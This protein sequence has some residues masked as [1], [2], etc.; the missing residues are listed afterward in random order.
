IAAVAFAL[1]NMDFEIGKE[2]DLPIFTGQ[3]LFTL[4]ATTEEKTKIA[5]PLGE[6]EVYKVRIFTDFS[7]KL[8]AK[9]D[10]LAY[11]TTD[12]HHVLARIDADF[13]VGTISAELT[14]YQPGKQIALSE[15]TGAANG[16]GGSGKP[17]AP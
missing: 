17:P 3:K 12:E 5:T 4:K 13:L 6:R 7:G 9:R 15:L 14:D 8:A 2:R 10:M 1:R 11:F 16:K